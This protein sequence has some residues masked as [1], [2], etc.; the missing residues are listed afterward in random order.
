MTVTTNTLGTNTAEIV[1]SGTGE[2]FLNV[3]S[4][5]SSALTSRGWTLVPDSLITNTVTAL[6]GTTVTTGTTGLVVG[7][8]IKF[9]TTSNNISSGT[10]YYVLTIGSGVITISTSNVV[11]NSGATAYTVSGSNVTGLTI[12]MTSQVNGAVALTGNSTNFAQRAFYAPNLSGSDYK[13]I[14][15]NFMDLTIDTGTAVS[16]TSVGGRNIMSLT[17]TAYRFNHYNNV[18]FPRDSY[19]Y[20]NTTPTVGYQIPIT[21]SFALS[22]ATGAISSGNFGTLIL[23]ATSQGYALYP[24]QVLTAYSTQYNVYAVATVSTYTDTTATVVINSPFWSPINATAT[25]AW[26]LMNFGLNYNQT[27]APAYVYINATARNVCIQCRNTD[28]TWQDWTAVTELENPLSLSNNWGLT[29]GYMI[30]NSGYTINA[31][32]GT[33]FEIF[34]PIGTASNRLAQTLSSSFVAP[35]GQAAIR[36]TPVTSSNIAGKYCIF[37]GPFSVPSTN[38]SVAKTGATASQLSKLIT[39]LGEVGY[40]TTVRKSLLNGF[41]ILSGTVGQATTAEVA[42]V[43]YKGISDLMPTQTLVAGGS[44]HWAVSCSL[45]TDIHPSSN[46]TTALMDTRADNIEGM[47]TQNAGWNATNLQPLTFGPL[48]SYKDMSQ[49][50]GQQPTTMGRLYG[51]KAVTSNLGPTTTISIKV[52]ASGFTSTSGSATDHFVFSY[53]SY[54]VSSTTLPVVDVYMPFIGFIGS[55]TGQLNN[56]VLNCTATAAGTAITQNT[57]T[58]T[59]TNIILTVNSPVVF[60]GYVGASGIVVGQTYYVAA[61]VTSGATF[62][63]AATPG[64]SA[65]TWVSATGLGFTATVGWPVRETINEQNQIRSSQQASVAFPK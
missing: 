18:S 24:G 30:G 15:V 52:D 47:F 41:Q 56:Y 25:S 12:T 26:Y 63:V 4:A 27:T 40:M 3:N 51:L 54:Y 5:V 7:M 2:S 65:I 53:P 36:S 45:V 58:F 16:Q 21:P 44:K 14:V 38:Y 42:L 39:P 46:I 11:Q 20:S 35:V 55:A 28:G 29:T 43:Y 37:T 10:T 9:G 8:P 17:N 33:G 62:T 50:R 48:A 13:Y 34:S 6:N 23:P 60:T 49:F 61:T 19:F 1:I 31:N 32:N 22:V 57:Y 64:G 59:T